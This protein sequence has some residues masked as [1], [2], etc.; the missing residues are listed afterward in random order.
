LQVRITRIAISPRLAINIL[1]NIPDLFK[2]D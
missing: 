2:K 1:L